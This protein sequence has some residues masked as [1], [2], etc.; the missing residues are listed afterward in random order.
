MEIVFSESA[1]GSLVVGQSYGK[2]KYPG[3]AVGVLLHKEDGTR[4]TEAEIRDAQARARER[5]RQEWEN[6]VPM[7][8]RPGDVYCFELA[9][10]VGEISQDGIGDQRRAALEKLRSIYP[11]ESCAQPEETLEKARKS[12]AAVLERCAAGE[13][14]RIW[15]SHNPDELCGMHWLMAQL[16][17]LKQR[18]S[19]YLVRL[20]EWEC[21]EDGVILSHNGWG[22]IGPGQWGRYQSLQQEAKPALFAA[23]AQ[24]WSR[25]REENAPLRICLNGNL[26]SAPADIYDSFILRE[27]DAQPQVFPEPLVIGN[28]LGKYQLGIGDAW[29]ALRIGKLI[30]EGLL[31]IAEPAPEGD[32]GY[33]RKLRKH[34]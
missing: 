1:R 15:Y 29:V 2:G 5:H 27:I 31:E 32:W 28:V 3:G 30:E 19:V 22:E 17:P 10:S 13:D 6:A 26:Q 9:W 8:G 7:S 34:G 23:C 4:P 18:G 24:K 14:V 12:L 11:P 33:R 16:R 21:R 20:P 25:L